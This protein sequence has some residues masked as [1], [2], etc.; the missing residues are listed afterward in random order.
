MKGGERKGER[1]RG[2]NLSSFEAEV[3]NKCEEDKKRW[4]YVY[5][6]C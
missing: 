6:T 2:H 3:N 1:A 4:I 5:E